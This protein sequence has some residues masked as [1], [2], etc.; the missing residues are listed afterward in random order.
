[1]IV[2]SVLC[3][4]S[5]TYSSFV[6]SLL[7][8]QITKCSAVAIGLF[9]AVFFWGS[10]GFGWDS[11][12]DARVSAS[13]FLRNRYLRAPFMGF[14]FFCFAWSGLS[15]GA[16]WIVNALIASSGTMPAVVDGWAP[17]TSRACSHPTLQHVPPFMLGHR[18]ACF[19]ESNEVNFPPGTAV[20]LLG[21]VSALGISVEA[22]QHIR[23]EG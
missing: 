5:L 10:R 3:L 12:A 1:M 16:P 15:S 11:G 14:V 6:P 9:Y 20:R 22:I 17:R 13:K 4:L 23:K 7:T 19:G 18:A 8:V 21:K 2:L